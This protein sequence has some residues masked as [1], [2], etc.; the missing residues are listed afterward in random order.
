M[1]E[2]VVVIVLAAGASSRLGRPKQ[3]LLFKQTTLLQYSI[4]TALESKAG[5]V[6]VIL[7]AEADTIQITQHNSKLHCLINDQWAEGMASSIRC[8][9]THLIN[10]HP[11]VTSAVLM[12][13][14]QPYIHTG[15]LNK[16]VTL[17]QETGAAIVASSYGDIKG[18]PAI[19]SRQLFPELLQLTGDTGAKK[20]MAKYTGSLATV[21]FPL[22]L[23]DIDTVEDYNSIQNNERKRDAG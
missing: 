18:I 7:G 14:D 23:I 10:Y 6:L 13:C 20:I 15:L 3:N 16:L 17:Q 8:G 22:G 12:A 19:F 5:S 21:D 9:I 11:S 2:D 1:Q 4:E